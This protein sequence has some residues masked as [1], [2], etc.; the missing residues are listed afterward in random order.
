MITDDKVK[1]PANPSSTVWSAFRRLVGYAGLYRA[2]FMAAIV[3]LAAKLVVDIGFATVQKL[4][5]DTITSSDTDALTRV[6]VICGIAC[7]IIIVC[8]IF[9]HYFRFTVH[10]RMAWDLRSRLF[11]RSNRLSFQEVQSMHS[12]DLS[13]RNNKDVNSAM[14]MVSSVVYELFYNLLLT[15]VSFIYLARSDVWIALLAL[16]SG[17][18]VFFCSRFFDRK[19]RN[20]SVDIFA[21]EAGLRALLQEVVQG[22]TVVRAFGMEDAILNRYVKERAELGILQRKR[23]VLVGL[24]WQTSAFINNVVMVVCAGMIAYSALGGGMS[25][26]GVLAFVILIGRV[27]WPFVHMSQTW[28]AVQEAL[29]ASDRVFEILDKETENESGGERA[30]QREERQKRE[31]LQERQERQERGERQAPYFRNASTGDHNQ[32]ALM[33]KDVHFAHKI[34]ADD[35][36]QALFEGLNLQVNAGETVAVVGPSGSG[37]STLVRLCCGLYQ[38]DQGSVSLHG[39]CLRESLDQGRGLATYVPQI[40]YL[41]AGTIGD[42]IAFGTEGKSEEEIRMAAGLAGADDFIMKLPDGYATHIGEHGASLSGGQKQRIA[43]ARAFLREAPLLLLDEATSALDNEAESLVQR[44]LDVLMQKRTTL[45]IA[46]RLSTVLDAD[47]ILVMEKGRIVEE[48]THK[49]LLEQQGLYAK[50]YRI[51]FQ[52]SDMPKEAV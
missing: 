12:G 13:S 14:S 6:T 34:S 35:P 52:E 21:R 20:L 32:P 15:L 47:R 28:G 29:G 3:L 40:P 7:A 9:Q 50:L 24:L 44:S 23:T 2:G 26:G 5:I 42:N 18:V 36:Q 31:G 19:L 39:V 46:H 22:M 30:V 49:S 8:L 1:S 45:V 48:G 33:L 4:F 51:Q 16:G 25:A 43:I 17:P 37:K 38:P 41:F 11:D 27:Q 10:F